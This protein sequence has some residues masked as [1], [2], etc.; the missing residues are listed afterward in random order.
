MPKKQTKRDRLD[1]SE[2]LKKG[3]M[4]K[5]QTI[6]SRLNESEGKISK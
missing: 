2:T 4:K 1:E 6:S 5:K 3:K